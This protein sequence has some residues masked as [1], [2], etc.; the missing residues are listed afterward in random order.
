MLKWANEGAGLRERFWYWLTKQDTSKPILFW[1][2]YD[3]LMGLKVLRRQL[4]GLCYLHAPVVLY[5]YL[6]CI[7]SNSS[8]TEMVDIEKFLCGDLKGDVP[9]SYLTS[10]KG[11]SSVATLVQ[12]SGN[13]CLKRWERKIP[14]TRDGVSS[15]KR[16]CIE[17][18]KRLEK[19][20]AL[21]ADF[22]VD[23]TFYESKNEIFLRRK[24]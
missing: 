20:P 21:V 4:S 2:H 19:H 7:F 8:N 17:V 14:H 1:E 18:M 3:H 16:A 13:P 24:I 9:L 5:H 12:L 6:N 22:I 15:H 10:S 23:K 11:G